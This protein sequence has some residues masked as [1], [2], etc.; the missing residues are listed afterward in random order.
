MTEKPPQE[1]DVS[2]LRNDLLKGYA[3]GDFLETVYTCSLA[4]HDDRDDL[5]LEIAALHNE[6]LV[7]VVTAFENLKSKSVNGPDFFLTR[8][9]FEKA[10]PHID[11]EVSSVMRCVLRLYRNAGQDMAAGMIFD[12]FIG[13]C[14]KDSSRPRETLAV[15]EARPDEFADLRAGFAYSSHGLYPCTVSRYSDLLEHPRKGDDDYR[16]N[17]TGASILYPMISLYAALYDLD[18][19]YQAVA[20]FKTEHLEHC[21]FQLWYPDET[22]E[23]LIYKN[24]DLHGAVASNVGV[25]RT[26]EELIK[27]VF[28]ECEQS[29][30]FKKLS[31]VE[32]GLWPIVI[33][34]CRHYRLPVPLH[35]LEGLSKTRS[36]PL[37]ETGNGK[38]AQS[39]E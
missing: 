17:V 3:D 18:E 22:S 20:D 36:H 13:F 28:D 1:R 23:A 15:V 19:L 16:K 14:A 39:A 26:K 29:P 12:S 37:T 27:E 34:A 2:T 25:D 6:G 33:V 24:T 21:N 30:H 11:A 38:P 35:L 7:D 31:A 10:L 9:V 5:A 8:H 32:H 4:N